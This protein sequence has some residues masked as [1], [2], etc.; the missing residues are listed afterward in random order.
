M[1]SKNLYQMVS[2]FFKLLDLNWKN[3][4]K[5]HL[6]LYQPVYTTFQLLDKTAGKQQQ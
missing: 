3:W 6:K 4:K 1:V 2:K 5:I